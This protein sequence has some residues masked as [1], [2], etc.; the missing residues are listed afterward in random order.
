MHRR[1][2]C[3]GC[4]GGGKVLSY[5]RFQDEA[6][7]HNRLL[8]DKIQEVAAANS[9][10]AAQ[11]SLA[12]LLSR[13]PEVAVI[14]GTRWLN[15]LEQELGRDGTRAASRRY[16]GSRPFFKDI[17]AGRGS[18]LARASSSIAIPRSINRQ[19]CCSIVR[20]VVKRSIDRSLHAMREQGVEKHQPCD[21]P[22][23]ASRL[24]K[25]EQKRL[26]LLPPLFLIGG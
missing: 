22:R 10:T 3:E 21:F 6:I 25:I 20:S 1:T 17:S 5:P 26:Y 4:A 14:P 24:R 7:Q 19:I 9:V 11:L 18:L 16:R 12:W 8:S 15:Y 13:K 23:I 2:A